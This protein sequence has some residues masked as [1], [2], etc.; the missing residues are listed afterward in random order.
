MESLRGRIPFFEVNTATIAREY[1][2]R[3]YP[4]TKL[5]EAFHDMRFGAVISS[6]CHNGQFLD[7][8]FEKAR[9]ILALCGFK[10]RYVLTDSGFNAVAL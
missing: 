8:G 9:D 3:P 1:R 5:L 10:E 6:D 2:T 7:C 4:S